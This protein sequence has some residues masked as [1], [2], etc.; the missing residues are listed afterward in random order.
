ME[1]NKAKEGSEILGSKNSPEVKESA[2]DKAR[3]EALA[4][5]YQAALKEYQEAL[6]L[7]KKAGRRNAR[8]SNPDSISGVTVCIYQNISQI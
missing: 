1:M 3:K 8:R 7:P 2:Q 6:P 4:K 5:E